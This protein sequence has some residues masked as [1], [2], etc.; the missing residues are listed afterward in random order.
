[1]ELKEFVSQTLKQI[2]EGVADSR[3]KIEQLGG[4]VNPLNLSLSSTVP[5]APYQANATFDRNIMLTSVDFDVMLK[6]EGKDSVGVFLGTLSAGGFFKR[7]KTK[8]S[9]T[10]ASFS[11]PIILPTQELPDKMKESVTFNYSGIS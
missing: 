3:K 2:A 6:E 4:V 5:N 11:V 8:G 1:M 10:R 9:Y 7:G